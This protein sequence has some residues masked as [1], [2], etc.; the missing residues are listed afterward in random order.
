MSGKLEANRSWYTQ[1]GQSTL[2]VG[3][4]N[5]TVASQSAKHSTK[6]PYQQQTNKQK[7]NHPTSNQ[8]ER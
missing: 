3:E 8:I 5:R 4:V 2:M 1:R 6:P 7:T